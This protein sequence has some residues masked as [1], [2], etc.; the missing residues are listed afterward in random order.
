[1]E[2]PETLTPENDINFRK[3]Y[4]LGIDNKKYKL[5]IELEI[6]EIRFELISISEISCF[7]LYLY[8]H[9]T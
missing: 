1:M 8:E 6:N 9:N 2:E 5:I 3:E 4:E 7:K